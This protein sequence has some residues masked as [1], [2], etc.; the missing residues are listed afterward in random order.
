MTTQAMT[1]MH[2]SMTS[3]KKQTEHMNMKTTSK[4][5]TQFLN[6]RLP[7]RIGTKVVYRGG[8]GRDARTVAGVIAIE[9]TYH[10][11]EKYGNE[12]DEVLHLQDNYVLTLDDGHWCYSHQVDGVVVNDS[13]S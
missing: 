5:K 6:E 11:S 13:N 1:M 2:M 9:Q 4:M 10:P 3:W 12:V 7:I 8:F